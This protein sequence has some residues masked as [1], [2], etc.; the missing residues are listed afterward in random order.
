MRALHLNVECEIHESSGRAFAIIVLP[1][2]GSPGPNAG[3]KAP[4]LEQTP[5]NVGRRGR[6]VGKHNCDE[7][8]P[9]QLLALEDLEEL[10]ELEKGFIPREARTPFLKRK[11]RGFESESA[12]LELKRPTCR[13]ER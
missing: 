2:S 6:R 8:R 4:H 11:I 3:I 1:A 5:K 13:L 7:E 12:P 9:Q 10:H